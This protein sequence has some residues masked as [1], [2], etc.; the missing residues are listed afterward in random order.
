MAELPI[1]I[2]GSFLVGDKDSDIEAAER[3]GLP[4]FLL[5]AN[6]GDLA[7]RVAA[8]LASLPDAPPPAPPGSPS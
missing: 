7:A 2:D 5:R 6:D 4:G 3:A 8:I 1:R